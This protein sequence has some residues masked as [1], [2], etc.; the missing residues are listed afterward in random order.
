MGGCR[1]PDAGLSGRSRARGRGK[2]RRHRLRRLEMGGIR[3]LRRGTGPGQGNHPRS[4]P[5]RNISCLARRCHRVEKR[6]AARPADGTHRT[7]RRFGRVPPCERKTGRGVG[8]IEGRHWCR[9][10]AAIV[11]GTAQA[12]LRPRGG[13]RPAVLPAHVPG[14][15]GQMRSRWRCLDLRED[16]PARILSGDAGSRP[17]A[18][19]GAVESDFFDWIVADPE[20]ESIWCAGSCA[21][22]SAIPACAMSKAIF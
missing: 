16:D 19:I 4:R 11:G 5:S 3:A 7:G 22:V 10:E 17:P 15:G 21:H 6:A 8:Q 13:K 20:G 1:A 9:P 12:R 2:I 14:G 18:S